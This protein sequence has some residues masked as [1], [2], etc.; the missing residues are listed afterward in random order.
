MSEVIAARTMNS[1]YIWLD[2]AFLCILLGVLLYTKQF[3]AVIAGIFLGILYFIV[4]YGIFFSHCLRRI[5]D[6]HIFILYT[7]L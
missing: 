1:L 2:I 4:D 3:Q 5:W 6:C 7:G